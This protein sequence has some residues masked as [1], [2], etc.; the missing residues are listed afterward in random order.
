M[1]AAAC[2]K[3][4]DAIAPITEHAKLK[5]RPPVCPECGKTD[6]RQLALFNR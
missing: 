4:F 5:D 6:T 2:Q 1:R 3:R